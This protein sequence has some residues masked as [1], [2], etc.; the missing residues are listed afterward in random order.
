MEIDWQIIPVGLVAIW[1]FSWVA[2]TYSEL[3][4]DREQPA[5]L[6]FWFSVAIVGLWSVI[7]IVVLGIG[8]IVWYHV[9]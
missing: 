5:R 4:T 1:F 2:M 6:G 9:L 3:D 8:Y 7:T